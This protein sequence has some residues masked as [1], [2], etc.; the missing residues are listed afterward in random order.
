MSSLW[1]LTTETALLDK[2]WVSITKRVAQATYT[3]VHIPIHVFNYSIDVVTRTI[4]IVICTISGVTCT[5]AVGYQGSKRAARPSGPAWPGPA[6]EGPVRANEL[7][8]LSRAGQPRKT[9]GPGGPKILSGG[10]AQQHF[11]Y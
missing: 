2:R 7:F 11:L 1:S 6:Q 8:M 9:N 4:A 3:V 5:K 10:P